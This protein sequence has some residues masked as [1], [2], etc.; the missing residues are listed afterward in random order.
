MA[1][2]DEQIGAYSGL[3][4]KLASGLAQYSDA[5]YDDLYQEGLISVYLALR[6]GFTPSKSVIRF[7]MLT[8]C[9]FIA[10]QKRYE[11]VSYEDM[12]PMEHHAIDDA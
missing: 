10:R 2:I 7:R 5:E 9:R 8:W 12:L 4:K 6:A 3:V 1:L 11:S